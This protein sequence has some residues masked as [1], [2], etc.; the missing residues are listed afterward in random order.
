MLTNICLIYGTTWSFFLCLFGCRYSI[1]FAAW[2]ISFLS[3]WKRR[4][5][6]LAFLWGADGYEAK[7]NPL[8]QFIGQHVVNSETNRDDVIYH[9]PMQRALILGSSF[10]V[11]LSFILFTIYCAVEA[12]LIKDN[13]KLSPEEAATASLWDKNK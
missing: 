13:N 1:F 11:S 9:K 12:T 8:A 3:S 6:E 10:C 5:T 2:S 4:E 7:Q